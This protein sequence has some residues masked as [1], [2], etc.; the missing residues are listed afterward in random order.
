M[1]KVG[2]AHRLSVGKPTRNVSLGGLSYGREDN[3]KIYLEK[4]GYTSD[5]IQA[6]VLSSGI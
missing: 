3:I 6:T 2:N 4:L 1:D 5:L